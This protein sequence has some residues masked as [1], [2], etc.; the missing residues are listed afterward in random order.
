MKYHDVDIIGSGFF[1]WSLALFFEKK[2]KNIGIFESEKD[3]FTRASL[4]NQ[5]RVHIGYYYPR[6][7]PT[8]LVLIIIINFL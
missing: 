5:G 1:V 3:A 4:V 6:S 8:A 2:G 7:F